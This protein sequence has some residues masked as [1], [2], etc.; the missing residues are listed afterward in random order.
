[1]K[2]GKILLAAVAFLCIGTAK[3]DIS[4]D[5]VMIRNNDK[6]F[7]EPSYLSHERDHDWTSIL[8]FNSLAASDN[9]PISSKKQGS[10]FLSVMEEFFQKEHIYIHHNFYGEK[11]EKMVYEFEYKDAKK[12]NSVIIFEPENSV[13]GVYYDNIKYSKNTFLYPSFWENPIYIITSRANTKELGSK[14]DL[15]KFKGIYIAKEGF[16]PF[17]AKDFQNHGAKEVKDYEEAY[18]QLLTGKADYIVGGYYSSMIEAYKLGIK[19]Y[20]LY[21]KEPVWKAAMFLRISPAL[22]KNPHLKLIKKYFKSKDYK[23]KRDKA[24]Y[25]L[26]EIYRES[27]QGVVPPTYIKVLPK[28]APS[29]MQKDVA[30]KKVEMSAETENPSEKDKDLKKAR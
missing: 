5:I 24:L 11:Y 26:L 27:T 23:I 19:D 10:L 6:G 17:L 21:S 22:A 1:M 7:M 4:Q 30:E 13:F 25:E 29:E 15:N 3:A 16:S 9:F 14:D 20:I 18:E 28:E 8:R 2:I 12:L